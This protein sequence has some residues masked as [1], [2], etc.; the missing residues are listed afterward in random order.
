MPRTTRTLALL[1]EGIEAIRELANYAA[2]PADE[3]RRIDRRLAER[4]AARAHLV[5]FLDDARGVQQRF[6]RNTA[7]VQ[8]HAA[9][10]RP[11]LDERHLEPQIG[12]AKCRRVPAGPGADRRRAACRAEAQRLARRRRGRARRWRRRPRAGAAA[13]R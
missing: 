5:R 9:E 10:R 11:A 13:P 6:R 12:G 1:R 7:D 4:D 2:L 3:L 8:A